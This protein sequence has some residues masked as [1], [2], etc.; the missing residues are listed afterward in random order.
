MPAYTV[1]DA[2]TVPLKWAARV[3]PALPGVPGT[4]VLPA[5]G[6]IV[7]PAVSA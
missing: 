4:K 3:E 2:A 1:P 5:A 7:V 6:V